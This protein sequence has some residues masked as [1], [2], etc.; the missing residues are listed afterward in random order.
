MSFR[1][2]DTPEGVTVHLSGEIDL[3]RSPDAR[4]ALLA[5]VAQERDVTVDM[6]EVRD[7]DSSGLARLV[8]A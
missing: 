6:S 3:D 4:K 2:T 1:T 7:M 5:A 8:E